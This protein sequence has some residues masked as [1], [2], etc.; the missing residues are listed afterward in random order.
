[1][2]GSPRQ[3]NVGKIGC[4]VAL[5]CVL[6]IFGIS[7]L[8]SG[9]PERT[10]KSPPSQVVGRS[11]DDRYLPILNVDVAVSAFDA[12]TMPVV[13]ASLKKIGVELNSQGGLSR[14]DAVNVMIRNAT[15]DPAIHFTVPG[16]V[17]AS[18]VTSNRAAPLLLAFA[19]EPG[20]NSEE[21]RAAIRAYCGAST[22]GVC[23]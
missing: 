20:S 8:D 19:R 15:K 14:I 17:M 23:S 2:L 18:V 22:L 1:M 16:K 4:F 12:N 11:V 13:A 10:A 9:A 7:L 6:L 5:V 21:G 3:R